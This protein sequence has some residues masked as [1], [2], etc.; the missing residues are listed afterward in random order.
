MIVGKGTKISEFARFYKPEK[1]SIGENCRID[2][3]CMFSGGSGITIGDH[4]HIACGVYLYGGAGIHFEDFVQASCH[5]SIL[6][7]SDDFYGGGLVGPQVPEKYRPTLKSGLVI[8]KRHAFLGAGVTVLPRV[9]IAEGC[10]IGAHSVVT[11]D[12]EPWGVYAGSPAKRIGER[13][14]RMLDFER[15][16]LREYQQKLEVI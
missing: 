14:Q 1:I 6:S 15:E 9:T 8:C 3:F 5:V 10:S 7:Q 2:D 13:S 16:F 4:I 12:T 11:K